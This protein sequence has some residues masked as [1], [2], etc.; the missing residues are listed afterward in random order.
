MILL[1]E[2]SELPKKTHGQQRGPGPQSTDR[3]VDSKCPASLA[4]LLRIL[5]NN[6][7]SLHA[8]PLLRSAVITFSIHLMDI[9]CDLCK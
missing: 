8:E 7:F 3:A 5:K 4:E 2:R 1:E 9:T 6:S